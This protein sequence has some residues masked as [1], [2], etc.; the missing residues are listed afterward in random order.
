MGGPLLGCSEGL[1]PE[2]LSLPGATGEPSDLGWLS[3]PPASH[4]VP[5]WTGDTEFTGSGPYPW[6]LW[7]PSFCTALL[8]T[9]V[10]RTRGPGRLCRVTGPRVVCRRPHSQGVSMILS[11]CPTT[12]RSGRA[13]YPILAGG[14]D[15][16]EARRHFLGQQVRSI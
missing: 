3:I 13:F 11:Q 15:A 10:P 1:S 16:Q 8:P 4:L 7:S 9:L 2:T 12:P 6:T 5:Y 14:V